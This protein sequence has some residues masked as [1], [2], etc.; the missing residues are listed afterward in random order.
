MDYESIDHEAVGQMGYSN[1]YSM[2]AERSNCF[3]YL[4]NLMI[5]QKKD[6]QIKL[7]MKSS[8]ITAKRGLLLF[9]SAIFSLLVGYHK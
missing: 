7:S 4:I 5:G 8:D 1:S 9:W 2:R 6:V 3:N